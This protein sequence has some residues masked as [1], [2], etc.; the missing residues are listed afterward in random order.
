M[1]TQKDNHSV[2]G[3]PLMG[4]EFIII[5]T[6]IWGFGLCVLFYALRFLLTVLWDLPGIETLYH[7]VLRPL[8]YLLG[9]FF[10]WPTVMFT[11]LIIT[12]IRCFLRRTD[13]TLADDTLT[14]RRAGH[15]D[16]LFLSDFIRPKTV[17]SYIGFHF[18]GWV[19]RRRYLIFQN[20]SGKEVKY[21]LYEYSEKDLN[22]VMQLLTR[23]NRTEQLAENDKTEIMLNA[24]QNMAEISI[25]PRHLWRCMLRPLLLLCTCSLVSF[26]LFLWLFYRMLFIPLQYDTS[27]AFLTIIGYGSIALSLASLFL[28][29]RAFWTLAVNAVLRVSC[30]R[31]I[32]F[33]GNM[34]QIDHAIYS[35]NRIDR[36]IMNPPARKLP[37]FGHYQ[38]TLV[39]LDGTHRYWLGNTAGLGSGNWQT[40]CR[41]IQGMLISCP[42]KLT[43][44]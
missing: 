30:P 37:L 6:I 16:C 31:K 10:Q 36:V 15:T 5:H 14:I 22:R 38:V 13:V 34:L 3:S 20:D 25:D 12:I 17:E 29:C 1:P 27:S 43:Y 19:F 23:V 11:A 18:V 24:F 33:A 41:H 7:Y 42:A 39:T 21:R 8:F 44:R 28:L 26:G 9:F 35:V 40:L 32:V 2:T 4:L